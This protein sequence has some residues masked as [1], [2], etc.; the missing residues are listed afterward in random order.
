MNI[1]GKSIDPEFLD[2]SRCKSLYVGAQFKGGLGNI[3]GA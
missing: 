1:V 2:T 3:D